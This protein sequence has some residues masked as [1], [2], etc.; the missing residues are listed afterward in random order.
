M[1]EEVELENHLL[2]QS[3]LYRI[4]IA[5]RGILCSNGETVTYVYEWL[6]VT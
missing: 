1:A 4:R 5:R 3:H 2:P 6:M